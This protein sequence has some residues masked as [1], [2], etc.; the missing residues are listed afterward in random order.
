M[1]AAD[2]M[3]PQAEEHIG[4]GGSHLNFKLKSGESLEESR[5]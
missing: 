5:W 2:V 4:R 3:G 1:V